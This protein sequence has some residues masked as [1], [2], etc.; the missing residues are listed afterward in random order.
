MKPKPKSSLLWEH[1]KE[2]PEEP[3]LI[4]CDYCAQEVKRGNAGSSR[5]G[6]TMKNFQYHME[7][8]HTEVFKK[9]KEK[10]DKVA[11]KID[12]KDET[13]RGTVPL[14][15][16]RNHQE[17]KDFLKRVCIT[18]LSLKTNFPLFPGVPC[19][20]GRHCLGRELKEQSSRPSPGT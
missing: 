11:V 17:R 14:F 2:K 3:H 7:K 10:K 1:G 15:N 18:S 8:K 19:T 5:S 6:W 4:V 20:A 12:P 16:L 13:V 9:M